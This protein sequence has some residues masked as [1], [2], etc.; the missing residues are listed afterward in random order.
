MTL[1]NNR[2]FGNLPMKIVVLGLAVFG[3]GLV[4]CSDEISTTPSAGGNDSATG[5]FRVD[6][7]DDDADFEIVSMKNGDPDNP[8][9]G[10]F[11]IR[12]RNIRYDTELGALVMDLS[13]KNL[14]DNTFDEPVTLTF[15]SLLPEGVTVLNGDN[16]ETGPGAAITFEFE[17][18]D[19]MWT[20]GEE[21][22]GRETHFGVDQGVSIGFVARLDTGTGG[23]GMG[24]I[25]G[26]VWH[27]VN[28]DGV[29][30]DGEAAVEGAMLELS[31][32]GMDAMT[33]TSAAD[34]TYGFDDLPSGFYQVVLK[35]LEGMVSTTSPLIYVVLVAEDGTVSS[36]LAANFGVTTAGGSAIISGLVWN[37]LNGDGNYDD[38]EPALEGVEVNLSGDTTATTTT[39]ADGTYAFNALT[40]GTYQIVSVGPDGWVLTTASPINVMLGTDDEVFDLGI[41]GWTEEASGGTA[42]IKGKVWNDLNGDGNVNDDEPGL[43]GITV[44]LTGDATATTTTV[45]DGTYAFTELTAG[46]YEVA[47]VGPDGWVLTTDSPIQVVLATDDEVFDEGSFGWM[48]EIVVELGTISGIVFNDLNNNQV[49][50]DGE[51]GLEGIMVGLQGDAIA[52]TTTDAD[53][54]YMFTDLNVGDYTVKSFGPA[55]WTPTTEEILEVKIE[56]AGQTV[57]GVHFGWMAVGRP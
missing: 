55:G 42:I 17:N 7:G 19:A 57:D 8:I 4:G 22:L 48:E 18:D 25:G 26:M 47:S 35:P 11:A 49:Q 36:F 13:V 40:A 30:D 43:E 15:L 56:T 28:E 20:P 24:S 37:D 9:E 51:P 23:N 2:L 16:E 33:T 14:G 10:P 44:A 50:D 31:T 39:A 27:D 6:V 52:S 12:G 53:G 29:M 54:A 34:G 21:S 38:G 41:F 46:S 5:V 32:E 3:L 1:K 45:A